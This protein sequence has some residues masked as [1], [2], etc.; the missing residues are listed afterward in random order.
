MKIRNGGPA[1]VPAMI[2]LADSAVA[3][4]NARGITEQWGEVPWSNRPADVERLHRYARDYLLRVAE[5]ADGQVVGV[6]VLAEELSDY[7]AR[8][9]PA[10]IPE[11]YVRF[12]LT[13]RTRSGSGI[14][15]AL[16]AD[17]REETVRRGLTLLRV[18]CFRGEDRALVRQYETLG[19]TES[20]AFDLPRPDGST[21]P[22]QI[23]EIRI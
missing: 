22:G 7:V 17:A 16:I 2:A 13:D 19:F 10:V 23:L 18:D 3:W 6:C 5:D 8:V 15:A 9:A 21:W 20:L 12:L 1:D 11:L 4:L 14:G